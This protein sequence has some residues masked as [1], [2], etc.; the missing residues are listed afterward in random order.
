MP[1]A[2]CVA[3]CCS[4]MPRYSANWG[5]VGAE[6]CFSVYEARASACVWRTRICCKS[7]RS[8][9]GVRSG[10]EVILSGGEGGGE[11]GVGVGEGTRAMRRRRG[12]ERLIFADAVGACV[13]AAWTGAR[14]SIGSGGRKAGR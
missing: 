1:F 9:C 11:T 10:C 13:T 6:L 8:W 5:W 2:F 4:E 3:R 12:G 7:L 14:I